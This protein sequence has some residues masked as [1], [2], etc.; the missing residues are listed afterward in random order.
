MSES[1]EVISWPRAS[2]FVQPVRAS[3]GPL[4]NCTLRS[5]S[6]TIMPS[7]MAL[8]GGGHPGALG[9]DVAVGAMLVRRHFNGGGEGAVIDRLG[10]KTEAAGALGAVNGLGIGV[11]GE[12]DDRDVET[13]AQFLC[14]FDAVERTFDVYVHED[15]IGQRFGQAGQ[16]RFGG[17]GDSGNLIAALLQT[18]RDVVGDYALVFH[19]EDLRRCLVLRRGKHH[20]RITLPGRAAQAAHVVACT[21]RSLRCASRF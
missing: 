14:G 4:R 9:A 10:E 6:M 15:E 5:R 12:E 3:A 7:A 11:S 1:T 13:L 16:G 8:K 17:I 20:M 2:A 21:Q 19:D 18:R